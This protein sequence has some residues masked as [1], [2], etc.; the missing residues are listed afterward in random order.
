MVTNLSIS[1]LPTIELSAFEIIA[2]TKGG[3]LVTFGETIV[4]D[5]DAAGWTLSES[6]WR[7]IE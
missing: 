3:S 7:A 2:E 4:A 6:V 1:S 5:I